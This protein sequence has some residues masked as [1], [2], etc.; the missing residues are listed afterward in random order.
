M[1]NNSEEEVEA[2]VVSDDQREGGE[3]IGDE[4]ESPADPFAE[5]LGSNRTER[6][7]ENEIKKKD[8]VHVVEE[9]CARQRYNMGLKSTYKR[10]ITC[11]DNEEDE[12]TKKYMYMGERK[13][14]NEM[15]ISRI[16]KKLRNY[17]AVNSYLLNERQRYLLKFNSRH[18]I[19]SD[20]DLISLDSAESLFSVPSN[21][22]D[23]L[24]S[25]KQ[26][27]MMKLI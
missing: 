13:L 25:I 1:Q 4:I 7:I 23:R 6:E 3:L 11:F 10:Y 12:L 24:K 22:E 9:L 17:E 27:V 2:E 26:R 18:V 8:L 5:D 20:S 21:D 15:D 14:Q 16:L 19:D